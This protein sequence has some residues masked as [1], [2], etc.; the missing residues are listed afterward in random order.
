MTIQF[1][2]QWQQYEQNGVYTLSGAEEARLIGLGIAMPYVSPASPA[3]GGGA[4]Y[5]PSANTF[6]GVM[7]AI[8]K[9]QVDLAA[10]KT[11]TVKFLPELYD[12]SG[13][14]QGF[15]VLSGL[16]YEGSDWRG[17]VTHSPIGGTII[18]GD[19][20]F[21]TFYGNHIDG[22][23]Q[24]PTME[25]MHA[26]GIYGAHIRDLSILNPRNGIKVG[27]KWRGGAYK[28]SV[29]N[30]R[31]QGNTGWGVDLEN[32]QYSSITGVSVGPAID[33]VGTG[34]FSGSV[35]RAIF[36][37]GNLYIADLFSEGGSYKTRGWC[38]H[39]Y[40]GVSGPTGSA[41]NDI[42][43]VKAQRNAS[44]QKITV[45]ATMS[46]A[47]DDILVADASVFPL[48]IGVTVST[49]A[50]GFN[51][52]QTYFVVYSQGNVVRLGNYIGGN[53]IRPSGSSAASLIT[54]G[55]ASF[56]FVGYGESDQDNQIQ[57]STAIGL[58]TEGFGTNM[59]VT[60]NASLTLGV[61]TV[62]NGQD[63]S[64]AS[65]LCARKTGGNWTS[66]GS[67]ITDFDSDSSGKFISSGSARK[68]VGQ[69]T[70]NNPPQGL[71]RSDD[72]RLALS[73]AG[74]AN[75]PSGMFGLNISGGSFIYPN[76]SFGQRVS[77]STATSG[78]LNGQ[79]AG[80]FAYVGTVNSTRT[81]PTLS[82]AA[83]AA[84]TANGVTYEICNA[85]TTAGVTLT[86]NT[87]AGQPFN[88]QAGKTSVVLAV[89]QSFTVRAQTNG[90]SD[91]FW[92]VVGNN[93]V[94]I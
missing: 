78:T 21:D 77:T 70:P 58:D 15:P 32:W 7:D 45:S 43:I 5:Y 75:T 92:Q 33:A 47:T 93:G 59:I 68:I 46:N 42:C 64:Q 24:L 17:N 37:H 25:A 36:N 61:G 29:R 3:S 34:R 41:F 79:D 20:T 90:G 82:G 9:A 8:A 56:E 74:N 18:K 31:V 53:P 94:T 6:G 12:L 22:E 87:A 69:T 39:S 28:S 76:A 60:Q 35:Q 63:V 23:S 55:F 38:V 73:L 13:A 65:T 57:P 16:A 86:I 44:G 48:D 2:A 10:G 1:K 51:R 52:F 91:W 89:G 54:Y 84:N 66:V 88:R 80:C 11:A 40:G 4:V 50:N 81:L 26:L 72:G 62:F 49:S 19:G 71:F 14:G 30:V 27:A 83:G 85:S 67:V